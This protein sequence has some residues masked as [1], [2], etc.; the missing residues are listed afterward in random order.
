MFEVGLLVYYMTWYLH[1]LYFTIFDISIQL[2]CC[3]Q[4]NAQVAIVI[5]RD[6]ES[7]KIYEATKLRSSEG[8]SYEARSYEAMK[9]QSYEATK[10]WSLE[11]YEAMK[12]WSCEAVKLRSYEALKLWSSEAMK[13]WSYE[14]MKLWSYEPMPMM[15]WSLKQ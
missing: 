14:A 7:L 3:I 13:L 11:S 6:Q 2:D 1:H 15:H 5:Q 10:L 9:L 8:W 12:L 4:E